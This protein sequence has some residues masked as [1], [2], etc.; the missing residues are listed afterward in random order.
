M[1]LADS[2]H[3][4]LESFFREYLC[5]KE[6]RLPVIYFYV[7]KYTGIL[8]NLINVHGITFGRRVFIKPILLT[9][10]QNDLPKLPE[11]LVAHEIM[12]VLQYRREGIFNFFYKYISDYWKNLRRKK[13]W[14]AYSRQEAYLEIPFEI[15]ARC[16]A[17]SFVEWNTLRK[18]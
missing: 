2:S 6:F 3:Q 4:R 15:E 14:G 10:N 17:E 13:N 5:D 12:H 8:T 7:G 1:R 18:K 16:A 11:D 9:L